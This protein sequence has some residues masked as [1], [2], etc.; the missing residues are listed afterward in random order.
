MTEFKF[1]TTRGE[2][3]DD[4]IGYIKD[5]IHTDELHSDYKIYIG[6]DSLP[7]KQR[8][9]TYA[10]IILVYRVGKGAQIIYS[11]DNKI[12]VYGDT[13]K[14]RMKNRLW[15][16]IYRVADLATLISNSD[17]LNVSKIVDFQVHIDINPKEEFASNTIYKDAVGYLTGMGFDVYTKPDAMAASFVSDAICRGKEKKMGKV[18]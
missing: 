11:R 15:E 17:L 1:K 4:V 14:D 9:A 8:T 16:E 12:K 10:T 2:Y 6:C 5:R 3:I 13:K 7:T 18:R